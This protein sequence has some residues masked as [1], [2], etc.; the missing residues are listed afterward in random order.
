MSSIKNSINELKLYIE[1]FDEI[2]LK[3]DEI[4]SIHKKYHLWWKCESAYF[5]WRDE[6]IPLLKEIY[7]D[8]IKNKKIRI[9]SYNKI[10]HSHLSWNF[11]EDLSS[12]NNSFQKLDEIIKKDIYDINWDLYNFLDSMNLFFN[13]LLD[14]KN[15]ITTQNRTFY[16]LD[17]YL[18]EKVPTISYSLSGSNELRIN[19]SV[20]L[21]LSIIEANI[22]SSLK[23]SSYSIEYCYITWYVDIKLMEANIK[24]LRR[25]LKLYNI[26]II[27]GTKKIDK[28]DDMKILYLK[29]DKKKI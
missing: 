23:E 18:E 14:I 2:I 13:V 28:L 12:M 24:S 5:Y 15:T 21:I 16:F 10:R 17:W 6:I 27:L 19:W 3:E 29:K 7:N 22:L 1:S 11:S 8:I 26:D 4:I 20:K 25:K 9:N